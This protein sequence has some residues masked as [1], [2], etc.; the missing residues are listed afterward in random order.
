VGRGS[1]RGDSRHSGL[2]D[3]IGRGSVSAPAAK[4]FYTEAGTGMNVVLLHGWTCDSHDWIT[5][6]PVFE[7]KYRLRGHGRS[8][9]KPSGAY[10]PADYVADIEALI[11]NKYPAENFII[12]GALDGRTD[13][14]SARHEKA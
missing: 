13:R 8:E 2:W 10:K 9:V 11:L 6:L 1:G 4:L 5:Q 3:R 7:S 14:R 12:V